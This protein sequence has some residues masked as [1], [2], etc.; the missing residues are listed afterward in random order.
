MRRLV[1]LFAPGLMVT[2]G[3]VRSATPAAPK[4]S[5]NTHIQ[6]ILAENCYAC[7][8]IDAAARKDLAQIERLMVPELPC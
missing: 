8:G 5:F 1:F 4:L 7:H 6:P 2:A 3:A